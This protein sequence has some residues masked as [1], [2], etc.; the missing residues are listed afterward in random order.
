MST[1]VMSTPMFECSEH[2]FKVRFFF[3][4]C[5]SGDRFVLF[6]VPFTCPRRCFSF[7]RAFNVVLKVA[8]VEPGA[9]QTR[10]VS[11]TY[12]QLTRFLSA[13]T[14][15]RGEQWPTSRG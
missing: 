15:T 4:A 2:L 8:G 3:F 10:R 5:A 1:A 7:P 11:S 6:L 14:H 9:T 13:P 12:S